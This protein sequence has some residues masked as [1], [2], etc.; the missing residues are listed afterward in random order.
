M[1]ELA[2]NN[3]CHTLLFLWTIEADCKIN[4]RR[5]PIVSIPR[6]SSS[7]KLINPQKIMFGMTL[8]ICLVTPSA[9]KPRLNITSKS[10][11]RGVMS[12]V[13]LV[14]LPRTHTHLEPVILPMLQRLQHKS[15]IMIKTRALM[16][17]AARNKVYQICEEL[18]RRMCQMRP[19]TEPVMRGTVR[20]IT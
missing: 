12:R 1:R 18:R 3:T 7:H 8:P 6:R 15:S 9:I 17:K 13:P 10:L 20:R 2:G 16:L 4:I 11:S 5:P 14:M 19:R